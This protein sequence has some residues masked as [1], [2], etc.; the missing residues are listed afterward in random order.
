MDARSS[1]LK[2]FGRFLIFLG[3]CLFLLVGLHRGE[4]RRGTCTFDVLTIQETRSQHHKAFALAVRGTGPSALCSYFLAHV[5]AIPGSC[6][7]R[8]V[9]CP[10]QR[11]DSPECSKSKADNMASRVAEIVRRWVYNAV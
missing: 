9:F 3:T 1:S 5:C 4:Y 6:P 8:S 11:R 2:S 7:A 10:A